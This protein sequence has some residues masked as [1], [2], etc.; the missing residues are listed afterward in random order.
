MTAFLSLPFILKMVYERVLLK[1]LG[2]FTG[3]SLVTP[4][5]V[6]TFFYYLFL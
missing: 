3:V 1:I 4:M 6:N 5:I 2:P